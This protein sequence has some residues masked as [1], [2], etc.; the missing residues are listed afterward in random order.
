MSIFRGLLSL[1]GVPTEKDIAERVLQSEADA[2]KKGEKKGRDAAL[3]GYNIELDTI[4][5]G[6]IDERVLAGKSERVEEQIKKLR[7]LEERV[8]NLSDEIRIKELNLVISYAKTLPVECSLDACNRYEAIL[9]SAQREGWKLSAVQRDFFNNFAYLDEK[10]GEHKGYRLLTW[11]TDYFLF[12]DETRKEEKVMDEVSILLRYFRAMT[13]EKG[14]S[15]VAGKID[16]CIE[17]PKYY[18]SLKAPA[19]KK[20]SRMDKLHNEYLQKQGDDAVEL[21]KIRGRRDSFEKMIEDSKTSDAFVLG[22][23]NIA[24]R[25][26]KLRDLF[27]YE[28]DNNINLYDYIN[29]EAL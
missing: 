27:K 14:P 26:V 15:D 18:S 2:L 16:K 21:L 8:S 10:L 12:M 19:Q 1:V 20:V 28:K 11:I 17:D 6:M 3:A 23:D 5:A 24:S 4:R 9:D 25:I 22:R 13:G 7:E 29:Q